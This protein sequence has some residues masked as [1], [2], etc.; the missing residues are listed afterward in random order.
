MPFT[1]IGEQIAYFV[2]VGV[3]LLIV[4]I[5]GLLLSVWIRWQLFLFLE[6]F[7]ELIKEK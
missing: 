6:S 7:H 3:L 4:I 5:G 1:V 2:F